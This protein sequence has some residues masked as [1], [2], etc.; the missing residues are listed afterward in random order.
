VAHTYNPD[1]SGGGFGRIP[2]QGQPWQKA[3]KMPSR[4][5]QTKLS[6]GVHTF[7][8]SLTGWEDHLDTLDP[9]SRGVAQEVEYPCSKH[10]VPR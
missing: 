9:V 2:V 7:H 10:K 4:S 6:V 3:S 5:P 8:L 1:Y